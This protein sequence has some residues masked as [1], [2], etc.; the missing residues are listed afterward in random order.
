[1]F[2][3]QYT[4][5]PR[6]RFLEIEFTVNRTLPY[7]VLGS[8]S[9]LRVAKR[10]G[11]RTRSAAFLAYYAGLR[12]RGQRVFNTF[13]VLLNKVTAAQIRRTYVAPRKPS[14]E[15]CIPF[16]LLFFF[17]SLVTL[18]RSRKKVDLPVRLISEN[19]SG[20]FVCFPYRHTGFSEKYVKPII[21]RSFFPSDL[22]ARPL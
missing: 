16:L 21:V 9:S 13:Y 22:F 10:I 4:P 1:M 2:L 3:S 12:Q 6:A 14:K 11:Y 19:I 8:S 15:Q 5:L 17:F 20:V 7:S 18:F